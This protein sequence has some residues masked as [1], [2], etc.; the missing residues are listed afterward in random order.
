MNKL[1]LLRVY[2]F[3][4][5]TVKLDSYFCHLSTYTY[6]TLSIIIAVDVDITY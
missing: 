5:M 6:K 1:Q 2:L 3:L 4:R